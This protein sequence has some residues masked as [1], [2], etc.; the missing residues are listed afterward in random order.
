MDS[1]S[2]QVCGGGRRR[3]KAQPVS[4]DWPDSRNGGHLHQSGYSGLTV[5]LLQ[6]QVV[7]SVTSL[8]GRLTEV[9]EVFMFYQSLSFT[10]HTVY[11]TKKVKKFL[12]DQFF[13]CN[14]APSSTVG[15]LG[16]FSFP[17]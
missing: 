5:I 2:S 14:T 11:I 1:G 12:F 15:N 10:K 6:Q 17:P 4:S 16:Y 9:Q 7:R 8:P 13:F 3:L